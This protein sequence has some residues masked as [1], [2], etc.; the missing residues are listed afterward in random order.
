MGTLHFLVVIVAS[1][2]LIGCGSPSNK[3]R[4]SDELSEIQV[5]MRDELDR[6]NSGVIWRCGD[7]VPI[8]A[9]IVESPKLQIASKHQLIGDYYL[10]RKNLGGYTELPSDFLNSL[11]LDSAVA[12]CSGVC[13]TQLFFHIASPKE[14][15]PQAVRLKRIDYLSARGGEGVPNVTMG[16]Q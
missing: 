2:F 6:D 4:P 3:S 7:S 9:H 12:E 8:F 10:R 16:C 11:I 5:I 14:E 13:V 1:A 15:N